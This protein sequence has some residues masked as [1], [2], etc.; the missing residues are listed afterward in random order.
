MIKHFQ[1]GMLTIICISVLTTIFA[2]CLNACTEEGADYPSQQQKVPTLLKQNLPALMHCH[3]SSKTLTRSG[4]D[5]YYD[6]STTVYVEFPDSAAQDSTYAIE[7]VEDLFN[8]ARTTSAVFHVEDSVVTENSVVVSET[9]A[10]E[11][12][13]PMLIESYQYLYNQGMSDEEIQE[14]LL[15]ENADPT[16]LIPLVLAL[17]EYD[18][19]NLSFNKVKTFTPLSL[20]VTPVYA[21]FEIG[22]AF[23]CVASTFGFNVLNASKGALTKAAIKLAFRT[24]SS[25]ISGGVPALLFVVE[26][27][28]CTYS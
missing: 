20:L 11:A 21:K 17:Q 25:T 27:A 16:V 19:Q 8:L 24:V 10:K 1:K 7:T 6:D 13:E 9:R 15:E 14:M 5:V 2:I 12:L 23:G 3:I 18:T 22:K 28:V 4:G 26:V